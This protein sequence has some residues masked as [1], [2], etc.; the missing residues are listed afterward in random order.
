[1]GTDYRKEVGVFRQLSSQ[2]LREVAAGNQDPHPLGQGDCL[3][4]SLSLKGAWSNGPIEVN[5]SPKRK[6]AAMFL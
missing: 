4:A 3:A 6:D 5:F 2:K 1:M